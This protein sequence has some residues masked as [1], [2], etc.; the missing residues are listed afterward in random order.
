MSSSSDDCGPPGDSLEALSL[1][2]STR[3]LYR[4]A[5]RNLL[6]HHRTSLRRLAA[7]SPRSVDAMMVQYMNRRFS[8]GGSFA[9]CAHTLFGLVYAQPRLQSKLPRS[10]RALKGWD[11]HRPKRSYPPLTWE[12]CVVIALS[13]AARGRHAEAVATVLGFDCYLRISEYTQLRRRDIAAGSDPR[14]G[15]AHTAMAIRLADT[16]TGPNKF[17]SVV[18]PQV[19]AA[20][21]SYLDG[22]A[23]EPAA[24]A[25]PFTAFRYSALFRSVC[26]SLGLSSCGFV[27]HSLRH[28]GATH[29][30]LCGRDIEYIKHRGRWASSKSAARYVQSAPALLLQTSV[31]AGL[32]VA[33]RVLAPWLAACLQH[34]RESVPA[35]PRPRA[36]RVRFDLTHERERD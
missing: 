36:R 29:D 12:L 24:L 10:R 25:F 9:Q 35:A 7:R 1:T 31:P 13:M 17:V 33:G 15:G 3:L 6:L 26:A 4:T 20:L 18:N 19:S 5:L 34:L 27:P 32:V 8:T 11:R 14:L 16:K 2:P 21:Q 22:A 30:H 28:G 23:L